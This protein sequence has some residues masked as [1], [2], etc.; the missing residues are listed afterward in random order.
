[1]QFEKVLNCFSNV[2]FERP[3]YHIDWYEGM[4]KDALETYNT[5]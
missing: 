1:M 2:D 5:P 4:K 3:S